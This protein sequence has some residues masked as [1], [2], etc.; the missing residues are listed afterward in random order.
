MRTTL[1]NIL[2]LV[3]DTTTALCITK[4]LHSHLTTKLAFTKAIINYQVKMK[5]D[6]DIENK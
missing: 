3:L 4:L 2:I 5:L 6:S 1:S